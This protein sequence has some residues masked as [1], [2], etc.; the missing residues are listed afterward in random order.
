M[1]VAQSFLGFFTPAS[2]SPWRAGVT[3]AHFD[4]MSSSDLIAGMV[5]SFQFGYCCPFLEIQPKFQLVKG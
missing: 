5:S 1:L 4:D 2:N 3:V